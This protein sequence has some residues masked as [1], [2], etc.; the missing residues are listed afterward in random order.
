MLHAGS[1]CAHAGM[2]LPSLHGGCVCRE[3]DTEVELV[4]WLPLSSCSSTSPSSSTSSLPLSPSHAQGYNL[5]TAG[6]RMADGGHLAW[7][8]LGNSSLADS[9]IAPRPLCKGHAA[10]GSAPE[11]GKVLLTHR[12]TIVDERTLAF[13]AVLNDTPIPGQGQYQPFPQSGW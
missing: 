4:V 2:H 5:H 6:Q 1:A 10:G 12:G 7:Q 9:G 3:G 11:A 13:V 8:L